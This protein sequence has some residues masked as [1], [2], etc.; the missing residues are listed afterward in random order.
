MI[1]KNLLIPKFGFQFCLCFASTKS[2]RPHPRSY[3]RR[4][5]EA[6]LKPILPPEIQM[7]QSILKNGDF[8]DFQTPQDPNEV[9]FFFKN[10]CVLNS[11]K[12]L[13]LM[14][15]KIP[16]CFSNGNYFKYL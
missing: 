3:K 16:R 1:Y 7:K 12:K 2:L 13:N 14:F 4:L 6:A 9:Y 11:Y 8:F 15:L 10:F 5:F